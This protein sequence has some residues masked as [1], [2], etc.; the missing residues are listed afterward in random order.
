MGDQATANKEARIQFNRQKDREYR[1]Q[2]KLKNPF[3]AKWYSFKDCA[4]RT[5]HQLEYDYFHWLTIVKQNCYICGSKAPST[6]VGV[7]R[8]DNHVGYTVANSRPCCW[9]CNKMKSRHDFDVFLAKVEQIHDFQAQERRI[10]AA[11]NSLKDLDECD[12][13]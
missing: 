8:F 10:K 4:K 7:D 6:G 12:F 1:L 11:V 9:F 2:Q 13:Q 5:N 3:K